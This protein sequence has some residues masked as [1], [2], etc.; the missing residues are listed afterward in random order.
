MIPQGSIPTT[1]ADASSGSVSSTPAKRIRRSRAK[2][3]PTSKKLR[4]CYDIPPDDDYC[5]GD[6]VSVLNSWAVGQY[7]IV[8]D[9]RPP[10]FTALDLS[11]RTAQSD[12]LIPTA[13]DAALNVLSPDDV[14]S[15]YMDTPALE[16][17]ATEL[18]MAHCNSELH[19]ITY[20]WRQSSHWLGNVL[21]RSLSKD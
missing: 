9:S 14:Y 1:G 13:L 8:G 6:N 16:H 11:T 19:I 21:Q 20:H 7:P 12:Y 4:Q 10:P 17:F 2:G 3:A 18:F 5:H 15:E